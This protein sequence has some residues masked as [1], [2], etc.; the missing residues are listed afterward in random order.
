MGLLGWT[1]TLG[2]GSL[3]ISQFF[4]TNVQ[5]LNLVQINNYFISLKNIQSLNIENEFTFSIWNYE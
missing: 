3:E 5:G 2:V 4:K 1:P